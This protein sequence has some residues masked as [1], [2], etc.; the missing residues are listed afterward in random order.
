MSRPQELRNENNGD[1]SR[2]ACPWV[3]DLVRKSTRAGV[4]VMDFGADTYPTARACMLLDLHRTFVGCHEDSV[5]RSA[6]EPDLVLNFAFQMLNANSGISRSGRVEAAAEVFIDDVSALLD[7][8]R[9]PVWKVSPR[10]DATQVTP[11]N[12]LHFLLAL[13]ENY[14]LY[15]ICSQ[16]F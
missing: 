1:L 8:K 4:L 11:S 3:R 13:Y 10:L 14:L 16:M 7:R 5:V 15:E 12:V 2:K 6:A 9:A